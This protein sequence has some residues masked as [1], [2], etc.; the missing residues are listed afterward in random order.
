MRYGQPRADES[1]ML[2]DYKK[3]TG[4]YRN[5]R[6]LVRAHLSP[7][8]PQ[9]TWEIPFAKGKT[10]DTLYILGS[11]GSINE[12]TSEMWET[13]RRGD[14]FGLNLW[15]YHR[16]VPTYFMFE[17]PRY[18]DA[19][20][21]FFALLNWRGADYA[22]TTVIVNDLIA[23]ED[24][25]PGWA[26][27]INWQPFRRVCSVHNVGLPGAT[28]VGMRRWLDCL[29]LLGWFKAR[30]STWYLPKRRASMSA[31]ITFGVLA[32][33]RRIVLCGVDLTRTDY[34]YEAPEYAKLPVPVWQPHNTGSVHSTLDR[35]LNP[36]PIDEVIYALNDRI[37]KPG[38]A[39][40]LVALPSSGLHPR[41]AA[42]FD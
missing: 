5:Y 34:F 36:V 11:G 21:I 35:N 27:K 1:T 33:Y 38:G 40:L 25:Q 22:D 29:R 2:F 9:H 16:H 4:K 39:E 14:S 20:D 31:A 10:S 30:P 3:L 18:R 13:I 28:E 17:V 15:L 32:G 6:R 24:R 42:A 7:H 37:V 19:A 41:L 12:Y 8:V 23:A 26:A